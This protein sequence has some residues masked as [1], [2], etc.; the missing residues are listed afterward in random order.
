MWEYLTSRLLEMQSVDM[1]A[2]GDGMKRTKASGES[3]ER[4]G[5]IDNW[6]KLL[7]G[8]SKSSNFDF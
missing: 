7:I 2:L 6:K 5:P 1:E 8:A 4:V 3:L